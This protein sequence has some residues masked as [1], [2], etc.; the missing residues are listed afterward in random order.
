M[1]CPACEELEERGEYYRIR[2]GR[3]LWKGDYLI[4]M[5]GL[6][7]VVPDYLILQPLQHLVSFSDVPEEVY[8]EMD[9]I[10][11]RL[12]GKWMVAEHGERERT[13]EHAHL[14]VF[15][16]SG[17]Q[18][19]AFLKRVLEECRLVW[20]GGI[21]SPGEF[22]REKRGILRAHREY[23]VIL[24]LEE[25]RGYVLV[26]PGRIRQYIR[27]VLAS[28][29]GVPWDWREYPGKE[30]IKRILREFSNLRGTGRGRASAPGHGR[31]G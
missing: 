28:I 27:K 7:P 19:E 2:R 26:H 4:L 17:P 1:K 29:T 10:L 21:K 6:G 18:K 9:E 3:Y 22:Y 16:L 30:N 31:T 14:H 25:N 20:K 8:R 15:R 11:G 24:D 13:V 23:I 12:K 5:P